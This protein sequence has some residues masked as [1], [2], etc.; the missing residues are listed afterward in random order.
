MKMKLKGV[1]SSSK[2]TIELIK[3]AFAEL[4]EEKREIRAITVTELV[5]KAGL[6]RGAFYSHFDNIYD[7]AQV[8]QEEITQEVF[9][10]KKSVHT[11]EDINLYFDNIFHFLKENESIYSKLLFSDEALI[12]MGWISKR[13]NDSLTLIL[14]NKNK[15][16]DIIFFT[17]GTINLI[18][19]Y[20]KKEINQSLDEIAIYIKAK[21]QELIFGV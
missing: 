13:I 2:R 12:F 6:T 15:E 4:I 3:K 8:F 20:F 10:F 7:V 1:N 5:K 18:F 19:K 11:K 14:N 17:D 9:E 16:L 21:A